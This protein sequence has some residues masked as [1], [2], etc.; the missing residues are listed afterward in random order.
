MSWIWVLETSEGHE[1]GRSEEFS[2]RGDA[3][4]WIGETYREL[5]QQGV[6]RAQLLDGDVKVAPPLSL[7]RD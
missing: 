6:D 4:S 1:Q 7:L 2:S 3:E 5:V